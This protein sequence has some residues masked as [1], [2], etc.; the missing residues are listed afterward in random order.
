M[1]NEI[2]RPG[3]LW[4]R[5]EL[6]RS[7]RAYFD[8]HR[9]E[10]SLSRVISKYPYSGNPWVKFRELTEINR[11]AGFHRFEGRGAGCWELVHDKIRNP[12]TTDLL[13]AA[14]L[15]MGDMT[16][17]A[18]SGLPGGIGVDT[19]QVWVECLDGGVGVEV[20]IGEDEYTNRPEGWQRTTI[21]GPLAFRCLLELLGFDWIDGK[22]TGEEGLPP[23]RADVVE[24][25]NQRLPGAAA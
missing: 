9:G 6:P 20:Q 17:S 10:F 8:A 22:L 21:R 5:N 11:Y 1:I 18:T 12:R 24:L 25:I 14:E 13:A 19:R 2:R 7:V 15:L 23:S 16:R 4:R 3:H